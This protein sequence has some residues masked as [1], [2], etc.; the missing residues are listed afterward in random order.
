MALFSAGAA[1]AQRDAATPSRGEERTAEGLL[2]R[3]GDGSFGPVKFDS[4]DAPFGLRN[5]N[6]VSLKGPNLEGRWPGQTGANSQSFARFDDPIHAVRGFIELIRYYQ[7]KHGARSAAA[8]MRRYSPAGDCSGAPS[9]PASERRDGGG[10][11]ENETIAPVTAVRA[12]QAAGLKPTDDMALFGPAGEIRHPD[13]LRALLDAVVTQELGAK[14]CPQPPKGESWIGCR[15]DDAAF[16]R[17][18]ELYG[19]QK[20]PTEEVVS[21]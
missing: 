16:N 5:N 17:A 15:V 9:I 14:H 7:E 3:T 2:A 18:V 1:S 8:I 4:R 21:R 13:R 10:C 11:P 12:A 19:R 6:W 20:G